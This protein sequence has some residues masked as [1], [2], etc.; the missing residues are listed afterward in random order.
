MQSLHCN[1]VVF[2]LPLACK[3]TQMNSL[4][5]THNTLLKERTFSVPRGLLKQIDRNSRL[6]AVKGSRGVGKTNFLLDYCNEYHRGDNSCLYVNVNN[7]FIAS[8]GLF[9]FVEL[10]IN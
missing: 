1:F 6:I 3:N 5:S 10:F 2:L 4:V 9:R 7:L 8:E